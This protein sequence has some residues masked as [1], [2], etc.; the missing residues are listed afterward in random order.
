MDGALRLGALVTHEDI[1]ERPLVRA[2]RRA[3]G[4]F[5]D[6]GPLGTRSQGTIGGNVMNASPRWTPLPRSI[7]LGAVA[8]LQGQGGSRK[9][10]V[11]N[12]FVGPGQTVVAAGELLTA[13]EL[14][15]PAASSGSSYVR[16]E[17]RR[18]MEIAIVGASASVTLEGGRVSA[19]HS[20]HGTRAHD[21]PRR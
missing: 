16:L 13:I 11:E 15:A 17:Y 19:A 10:P 20:D 21:P 9:V 12:L 6:R 1:A 4:C 3:R 8:T 18:Q 7:C 14:P 5:G 2:R